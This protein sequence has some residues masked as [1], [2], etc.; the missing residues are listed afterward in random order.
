MELYFLTETCSSGTNLWDFQKKKKKD[1]EKGNVISLITRE[2]IVVV[3]VCLG[4]TPL[5]TIFQSYHDGVCLQQ[6]AHF[7]SAASLKYHVPNI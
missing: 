2:R 6:G 7:Y 4:L 1:R 5:S 3:V